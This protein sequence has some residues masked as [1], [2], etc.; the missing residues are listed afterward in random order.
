MVYAGNDASMA[1]CRR[2]GMAHLGPTTKYYDTEL[3]LFQVA[4][5][6][7]HAPDSSD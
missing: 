3:E 7:A 6:N 4:A 1:V 2:L 5:P